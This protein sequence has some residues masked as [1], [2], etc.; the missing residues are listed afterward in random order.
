MEFVGFS[1]VIRGVAAVMTPS[2]RPALRHPKTATAIQLTVNLS[3]RLPYV[4]SK[5][6]GGPRPLR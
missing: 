2:R 4:R 3:N 6:L 5:N 1:A